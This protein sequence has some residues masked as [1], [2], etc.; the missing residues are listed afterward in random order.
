[1][2]SIADMLIRIKNALAVKKESVDLPHS[3]MKEAIA[4]LLQSEG[5]ISKYDTFSRVN[6]KQ[7]R[8]GLK[9]SGKKSV[10]EGLK[11][12]SSPGRRV[13]VGAGKLPRIRS[14]FGTAI[15]ST[16][17]GLMTDSNAREQKLGGEVIC[18]VW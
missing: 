17:K 15:I 6:K 2:D 11:R 8:L 18:Y 9:Y 12:V 14:G 3:K 16:S 10:V 5:F 4:S 1:M 13:Y 7:L